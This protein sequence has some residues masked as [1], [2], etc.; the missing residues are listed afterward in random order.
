MSQPEQASYVYAVTRPL[1]TGE[2]GGVRGVG[3]H[4]V[5]LVEEDGLVA[6]VSTVPLNEFDEDA[7]RANLEDL[8]WLEETAR[9]HHSVVE[10]LANTATTVPLRL[11]TVYRNEDR[12]R[13]VLRQDHAMFDAVLRR[14]SGRTEYSVKVYADPAERA[15]AVEAP[16]RPGPGET[17]GKAYL[18][19][20]RE[21]REHQDDTWRVAADLCESTDT[22]LTAW[23]RARA[24]HR[25]QDSSLA[26]VPGENV[27]NLAYLVAAEDVEPFLAEARRLHDHAPAGTRVEVSGPWAP[28]SFA[29]AEPSES[30]EPDGDRV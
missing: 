27:M 2:L 13:E 3:R 22:A 20:R 26:G 28:Y 16:P 8:R 6:V 17:P 1:P 23:A 21:Q 15:A 12:V 7:L 4:P 25:P 30:R 18:R 19:R 14:L 11:A 5:R 24:Q 29:S 9:A 10:A